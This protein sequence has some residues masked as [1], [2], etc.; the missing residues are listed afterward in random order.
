MDIPLQASSPKKMHHGTRAVFSAKP[1]TFYCSSPAFWFLQ[2]TCYTQTFLAPKLQDALAA[3]FT[4]NF[5]RNSSLIFWQLTGI[6]CSSTS[7]QC[8][9]LPPTVWLSSYCSSHISWDLCLWSNACFVSGFKISSVM[10]TTFEYL[11]V[12]NMLDVIFREKHGCLHAWRA[13][14]MLV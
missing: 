6:I 13:E 4:L 1:F 11:C 14:A 8:L 5:Q 10:V 9:P 12:W 7:L 3:A 2:P